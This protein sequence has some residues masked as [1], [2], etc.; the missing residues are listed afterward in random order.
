MDEERR[1]R[2]RHQGTTSNRKAKQNAKQSNQ[3]TSNEIAMMKSS[4]AI[5]TK[6]QSKEAKEVGIVF[7]INSKYFI[8]MLVFI[9]F[10]IV[11]SCYIVVV[12]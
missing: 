3:A 11:C 6:K 12:N 9:I 10:P 2:V 5:K 7:R 1:V 4:K 8:M